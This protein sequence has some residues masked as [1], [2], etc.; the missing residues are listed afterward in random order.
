MTNNIPEESALYTDIA[1]YQYADSF[2]IPL[3]RIAIES[4]ELIPAF[5][6][7]AP[8]WVD[9][10]FILRNKIFGCIGLKTGHENP[11][12]F[13]PPYQIRQTIGL[14]RIMALS[15]AEVILG[16]DDSHLDFRISLLL[17]PSDSG[18]PQ[19]A[20]STLVKTKNKIGTAYFSIV[21]HF[22]RLIVPIMVKA[23]AKKLD[24]KLLPQHQS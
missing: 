12:D 14:F 4:W 15:D 23:M 5:F 19:L 8:N 17:I 16:E 9:G 6:Q 7:S 11:R 3:H 20:I 22:H 13:N 21:K 18:T 24:G 2:A 10:L 1:K